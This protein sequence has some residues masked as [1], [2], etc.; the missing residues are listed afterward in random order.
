M[1]YLVI[2]LC[3]LGVLSAVLGLLGS[4]GKS[5]EAPLQEGVS[6]NT[7]NGSNS[8]CEQECMMEAAT[9]AP[10]YFDDEELDRYRGKPS[11][12]YAPDEVEE[13]ADV[14]YTMRPEEVAAWNRSLLL[15]GIN[16][17]DALKDE[18]IAFIDETNNNA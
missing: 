12:Q 11:D 3:V 15:R 13:F 2:A 8:R 17:P 5:D 16:L 9:K 14:L 10:E 18:V 1:L 4:R 6:C 7:C